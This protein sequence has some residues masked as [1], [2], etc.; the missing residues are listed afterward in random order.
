MS[1]ETAATI[2]ESRVDWVADHRRRYLRSGGAEGHIEDLTPV[3]GLPFATHC[4]VKYVGR[5]SGRTLITGLTYADI[6]GE[7][8]VCASRGGSDHHPEWYLNIVSAHH[9][10]FQIGTQA[11]R[12]TWREPAGDERARIWSFMTTCHP[13]YAG[14]QTT[15][16]RVLPLV[17][18]KP[19][20]E[21][22]VFR[23]DE[24][25]PKLRDA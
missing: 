20:A 4:L 19:I 23:E 3:G 12:A 11:F 16:S 9:V 15:T 1:D 13:F 5:K 10:D 22:P 24:I 2:R 18:M 14:Y 8:V 21:I 25:T 6:G 17:M 7:I